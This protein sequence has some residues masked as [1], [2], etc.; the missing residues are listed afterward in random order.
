MAEE[1]H[2]S[3]FI[4]TCEAMGKT[5]LTILMIGLL[6]VPGV[7][8]DRHSDSWDNLYQLIAG[9]AV[10]VKE[11]NVKVEKGI[12]VGFADQFLTIHTQQQNLVSPRTQISE[13]RLRPRR[14]GRN[15]WIGAGVEAAAG[16]RDLRWHRRRPFSPIAAET[17]QI[18]S[19][20]YRS[21]RGS[22]RSRICSRQSPQHCLQGTLIY[23]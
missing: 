19:R 10:E 1:L 9:Q 21:Y 22:G 3:G 18:Y 23:R 5:I 15:T 7:A 16:F 2:W 12:F 6:S 17:S 11:S 4:C 20:R 14:A 8:R 13:I